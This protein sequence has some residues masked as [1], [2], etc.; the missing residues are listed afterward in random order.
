[1]RMKTAKSNQKQ[2]YD[3]TINLQMP[4]SMRLALERTASARGWTISQLVR[5]IIRG[6]MGNP[7][8]TK[9]M[10]GAPDKSLDSSNA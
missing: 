5:E 9:P 1:M 2:R 10:A 8:D 3:S 6:W 4:L 7:I